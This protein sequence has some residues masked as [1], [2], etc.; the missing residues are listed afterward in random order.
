MTLSTLTPGGGIA[1]LSE[2]AA[3]DAPATEAET[4]LPGRSLWHVFR[5]RYTRARAG[6]RLRQLENRPLTDIGLDAAQF[7]AMTSDEYHERP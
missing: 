4:L 6:P 5:E 1:G 3:I 7:A 2:S